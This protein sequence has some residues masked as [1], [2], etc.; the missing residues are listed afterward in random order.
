MK[1]MLGGMLPEGPGPIQLEAPYSPSTCFHHLQKRFC[2][3]LDEMDQEHGGKVST[4]SQMRNPSKSSVATPAPLRSGLGGGGGTKSKASRSSLIVDVFFAFGLQRPGCVFRI[5]GELLAGVHVWSRFRSNWKEDTKAAQQQE[6]ARLLRENAA[7]PGCVIEEVYQRDGSKES[8]YHP[9]KIGRHRARRR[10]IKS[11]TQIV[12]FKNHHPNLNAHYHGL[13]PSCSIS[14]KLTPLN[15]D[16]LSLAHLHVIQEPEQIQMWMSFSEDCA[17]IDLLPQFPDHITDFIRKKTGRK[18]LD[19]C[20]HI[21]AVNYS[22][23]AGNISLIA[24]FWLLVNME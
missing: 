14:T 4:S 16:R 15:L 7:F 18:T 10:K 9:R 8:H 6:A 2:S 24:N 21:A 1:A 11:T 23:V 3:S 13:L 20:F 12:L 22:T 5:D 19:Q 17:A